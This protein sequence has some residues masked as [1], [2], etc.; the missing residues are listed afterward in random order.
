MLLIDPY[1]WIRAEPRII[2]A[3]IRWARTEAW[4]AEEGPTRVLAW[5]QVTSAFQWL[6]DGREQP[7]EP[8]DGHYPPGWFGP[9]R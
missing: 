7:S 5:N 1:P 8:F 4:S 2:A 9:D 6:P 3:A